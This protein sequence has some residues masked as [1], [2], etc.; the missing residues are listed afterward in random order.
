MFCRTTAL[1]Q[2]GSARVAQ[3]RGRAIARYVD[4]RYDPLTDLIA[5]EIIW[6]LAREDCKRI[7]RG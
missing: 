7:E 5:P 2:A 4:G 1:A 3:P 6:L